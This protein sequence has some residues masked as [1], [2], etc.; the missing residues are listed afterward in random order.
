[1][2]K[3]RTVTE[4]FV[5]TGGIFLIFSIPSFIASIKTDYVTIVFGLGIVEGLLLSSFT[6]NLGNFP[7]MF[8]GWKRELTD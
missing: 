5:F 4:I 8:S 1:M 7:A 6:R 3:I 2:I